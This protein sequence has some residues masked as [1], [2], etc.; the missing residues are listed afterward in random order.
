MLRATSRYRSPRWRIRHS[1]AADPLFHY[2]VEAS[3]TDLNGETQSGSTGLVVGQRRFTH[4]PRIGR[5][6]S[7]TEADSLTVRVRNL[8]GE[9]LELPGIRHHRTR[10]A[11]RWK[12]AE[13]THRGNAPT[14]SCWT[15]VS[16]P[17]CSRTTLRQRDRP[18]DL[19]GRAVVLERNDVRG[20]LR[21]TTS[22]WRV[23]TYRITVSAQDGSERR[24]DRWPH[25]RPVRPGH[26]G[27][28][29][30]AE[31]MRGTGE[32]QVG[33]AGRPSCC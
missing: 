11:A 21:W 20:P 23:G 19:A 17:G 12:V 29:F 24:I 10:G 16:T 13:R 15:A 27:P 7:R 5:R 32:G 26:G 6:L 22:S 30:D 25:L 8:N 9:A 14:A 4:R 1:Q 2:R 33:R 28:A 3:V 31:A 18:G